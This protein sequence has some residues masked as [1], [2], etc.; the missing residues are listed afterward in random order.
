[1][2]IEFIGVLL[3][4][5]NK[6]MWYAKKKSIITYI[7]Y[8]TGPDGNMIY[9]PDGRLI[10][11]STDIVTVGTKEEIAARKKFFT[12]IK[13]YNKKHH[14]KSHSNTQCVSQEPIINKFN[15][16]ILVM[17]ESC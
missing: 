6:V 12:S 16:R 8:A 9:G 15:D 5:K 17:S 2:Y 14:W 13:E 4:I 3:V 11:E 7:I 10:R 1:M